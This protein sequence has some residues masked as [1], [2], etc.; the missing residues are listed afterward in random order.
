MTDDRMALLEL[1]EKAADADLV[2]DVLAFGSAARPGWRRRC[3]EGGAGGDPIVA[4][5]RG[6]RLGPGRAAL[7]YGCARRGSR[8]APARSAAPADRI[9]KKP[10]RFCSADVTKQL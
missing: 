1:V 10:L 6:R 5:S 3:E 7:G 9:V 4:P 8:R 2:R